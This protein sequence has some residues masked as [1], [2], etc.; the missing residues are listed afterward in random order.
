VAYKLSTY[1]TP[2]ATLPT[3]SGAL[4]RARA[5][6]RISFAGGTTDMVSY[7]VEHGGAVL[8]ST[9][10]RYAFVSLCP[11]DDT[12]IQIQ[13]LDF[14]LTVKYRIDEEPIFDGVLDLAKAAVR[15]LNSPANHMGLDLYLQSD[16]PAGSGLGGSASLAAAVLGALADFAR[17]RL[18]RYEMAE[19]AYTIERTDLGISGGKQDQYAAVFGGFNLIEF[20][21]EGVVVTPLRI[22]PE[23]LSDLEYHLMLCYTGKTRLS[24]GLIDKQER[25]YRQG[26][27][28]TL[29]GLGAL[30]QLAY[31]MKDAL[32]KGRLTDFAIMLDHAWASKLKVNREITDSGIDEMYAEARRCGVLGGKLLGAGGGG[33]LLLFCEGGK[34]RALRERL[35]ALGGQFADFSFTQEGLQTWQSACL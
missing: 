27:G 12:Q 23:T 25:L 31:D 16:A 35:E 8:A 1:A 13:S 22:A 5:P 10:N 20:S 21:R 7:Y 24:A 3:T 29:E 32:M 9:I 34:K 6:L 19:L 11:R 18:D 30:R 14:D 26:R 15:R 2:T 17:V 33:Y 4:I 28:E